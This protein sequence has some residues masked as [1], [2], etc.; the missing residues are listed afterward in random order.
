MS[1]VPVSSVLFVNRADPFYRI[2]VI[3]GI[4]YLVSFASR[5]ILTSPVP[6]CADQPPKVFRGISHRVP[7][8]TRL[9]ARADRPVLRR[10]RDWH[11]NRDI[12][13]AGLAK[14]HQL[15]RQGPGDRPGRP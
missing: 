4:L 3:Y 13:G 12:H 15:A 11:T 7:A 2:S 5:C 1:D 8:A 14:D 10:N 9:G 6:V